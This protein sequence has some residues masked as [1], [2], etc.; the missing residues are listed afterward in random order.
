M[1]QREKQIGWIAISLACSRRTK[2]RATRLAQLL[3][4]A[5][6]VLDAFQLVLE[7]AQPLVLKTAQS[8]VLEEVQLPVLEARD[9]AQL[10]VLLVL[11]VAE[12]PLLEV[13]DAAQ[14][15]VLEVPNAAQLPVLE[16]LGAAQ[17]PMLEVRDTAALPMLVEAQA[18]AAPCL[19]RVD[20]PQF[21]AG[22]ILV[23]RGPVLYA[24]IL[25]TTCAQRPYALEFL[26]RNLGRSG[27]NW[28]YFS[29]LLTANC[30]N[31]ENRV[32]R[33]PIMTLADYQ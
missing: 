32:L 24:A 26:P 8:V 4:A 7:A 27:M 28:F 2:R 18:A 16:V 13:R 17:L 5:H 11:E 15:P 25:H 3:Q 33:S 12:L 19:P 21:S 29:V 14:V 23:R 9:S 22:Q 6:L 31:V 30:I 20:P 10:P 1:Q